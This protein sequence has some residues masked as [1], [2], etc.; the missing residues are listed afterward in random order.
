[1]GM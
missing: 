1:V